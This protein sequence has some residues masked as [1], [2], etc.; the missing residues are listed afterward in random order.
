[1]FSFLRNRKPSPPATKPLS[2]D[3]QR[4]L[5]KLIADLY[6]CR[7]A[8]QWSTTVKSNDKLSQFYRKWADDNLRTIREMGKT[9]TDKLPPGFLDDDCRVAY[10][11]FDDPPPQTTADSTEQPM[12]I[13][14]L[15]KV[16]ICDALRK[17]AEPRRSSPKPA[18]GS[19]D[20]AVSQ[21]VEPSLLTA[22]PAVQPAV[23]P[24][25]LPAATRPTPAVVTMP[26][27]SPV[28]AALP[29]A[30]AAEPQQ[31]LKRTRT[32]K[33]AADADAEQAAAPAPA[34]EPQ[35]K[36]KRTRTRKAAADAEQAA[37]PAEAQPSVE[38]RRPRVR[39]DLKLTDDFFPNSADS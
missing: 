9:V 14:E 31:K 12:T 11:P 23:P 36:P 28:A 4:K 21:S 38:K 20:V 32:R 19:C 5:R 27:V 3:R 39:R 15:F 22:V 34:A 18:R 26:A 17:L 33:A 13:E 1:M 10:R 24:D 29:P 6:R 37:A 25:P 30:P 16:S 2:P 7:H 8:L 35:Q